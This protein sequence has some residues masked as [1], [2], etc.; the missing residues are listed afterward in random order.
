MIISH[1]FLLQKG[2]SYLFGFRYRYN[3]TEWY[4]IG[5]GIFQPTA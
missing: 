4:Q 3:D 1:M 5:I 2:L